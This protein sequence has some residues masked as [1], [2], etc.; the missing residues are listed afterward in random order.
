MVYNFVDKK[1]AGGTF[2]MK[3]GKTRNQL[4]NYTNQF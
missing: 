2:K 1:A 3:L 4:K